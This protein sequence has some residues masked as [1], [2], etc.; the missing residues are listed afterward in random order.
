MSPFTI[1]VVFFLA[2]LFIVMSL[3]PL[4]PGPADMD[5]PTNPARAKT[6]GAH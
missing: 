3:I 1:V 2:V 5:S 4:L 6:K